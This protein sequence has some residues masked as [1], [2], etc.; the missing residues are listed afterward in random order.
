MLLLVFAL[1]PFT[2]IA[3]TGLTINGTSLV[4][5]SGSA[6]GK[7]WTYEAGTLT[8]SGEG[9]P[10]TLSGTY[11]KFT[12]CFDVD[13]T[14]KCDIILDNLTLRHYGFHLNDDENCKVNLYIKGT[15]SLTCI[16]DMAGIGVPE[17]AE[18]TIDTIE[19][20]SGAFLY[21]RGA[22]YSPAIGRDYESTELSSG[23]IIINGG[24]IIANGRG[25]SA[26]I[27]GYDGGN[28]GTV[29]INGGN[30]TAKGGRYA[31]AIGGGRN[32]S[33]GNI[34]INGGTVKAIAGTEG[35]GIGEGANRD[36]Q[37]DK[38]NIVITG[39]SVDTPNFN[40]N[41]P[42]DG[43]NN[44]VYKVT[45]EGLTDSS[46]IVLSEMPNNYGTNDI[47]TDGDGKV[48]LY[49][50]A[51]EEPCN[52]LIF[53][54]KYEATVTDDNAAVA[55]KTCFVI[56]DNRDNDFADV[57]DAMDVELRRKFNRETWNT[58]VLP[59]ELSTNEVNTAF[60]NDCKVAYFTN[61][62]PN[63]IELNTQ[64]DNK[65]IKANE[66]VL[67]KL[68]SDN[69]ADNYSFNTKTIISSPN[70]QING[71]N[72][73]NFIGTYAKSYTVKDGEY[74]ISGDKLWSSNGNTTLAG[75][76]AYFTVPSSDSSS[77]AKPKLLIVDGETTGISAVR[78]EEKGVRNYNSGV[79]T[80]CGQK[81]ADSL[82]DSRM[83]NLKQGIYIVNGK[84]VIIK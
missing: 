14:S 55:R 43:K 38:P 57:S 24:T 63:T 44:N 42:T 69:S 62:E 58:L 78:S 29:I 32:G 19:G 35:Y 8:I 16:I 60:G 49:L 79:Y 28:N 59:F 64:G 13:I 80:L 21:V 76:R 11:K 36:S 27:G 37:S 73:I 52:F 7:G 45:V 82:N 23:T 18:L 51:S 48:Y 30:V 4:P 53:P 1:L 67:I 34:I 72:G 47:K 25:N 31:A 20:E 22:S 40:G 46:N 74:F 77:S 75:T 33:G 6:S 83:A 2:A 81:V 3:Q 61:S 12:P 70:P 26:G 9:S 5:G 68:G 50:P 10:Y 66:P 54:Y 17:K 71:A 41:V 39:G 56:D 84:K 65:G 15:D